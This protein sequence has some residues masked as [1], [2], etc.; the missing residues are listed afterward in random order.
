MFITSNPLG[1]DLAMFHH[2]SY[3]AKLVWVSLSTSVRNFYSYSDGPLKIIVITIIIIIIIIITVVIVGGSVFWCG[4]KKKKIN[5][6]KL[7][8]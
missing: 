5:L 7:I 8:N 6:L 2:M 4:F 1:V 3:T